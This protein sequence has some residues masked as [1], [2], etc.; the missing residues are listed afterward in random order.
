MKY[1]GNLFP[2][3]LLKEH[4]VQA[5]TTKQL[6]QKNVQGRIVL[7][8]TKEIIGSNTGTVDWRTGSTSSRRGQQ[9]LPGIKRVFSTA[10]STDPNNDC[11]KCLPSRNL[12]RMLCC[13]IS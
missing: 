7:S 2:A 13:L 3:C 4:H 12:H 5:V 8:K 9:M 11:T 6:T 10:G 1:A